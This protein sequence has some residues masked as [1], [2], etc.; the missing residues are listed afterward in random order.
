MV[1]SHQ[2]LVFYPLRNAKKLTFQHSGISTSKNRSLAVSFLFT[3]KKTVSNLFFLVQAIKCG[4]H[5]M[6]RINLE[7]LYIK[8]P[9]SLMLDMSNVAPVVK[10]ALLVKGLKLIVK[11][12]NQAL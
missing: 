2:Q 3:D 5:F 9:I 7:L 8:H 6:S 1:E 10:M 11:T 4:H 12:H